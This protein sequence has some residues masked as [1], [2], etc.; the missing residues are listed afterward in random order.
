LST[1]INFSQ[2][3]LI[4]LEW[5]LW[6]FFFCQSSPHWIHAGTLLAAVRHGIFIPWD[7]DLDYTIPKNKQSSVIALAQKHGFK[8]SNFFFFLSNVINIAER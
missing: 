1:H 2:N 8:V 7:D 5:P 3:L 4:K 6:I